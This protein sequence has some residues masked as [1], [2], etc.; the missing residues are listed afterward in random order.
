MNNQFNIYHVYGK[1]IDLPW[2][3]TNMCSKYFSET[4]L[5]K[6][7]DVNKNIKLIYDDRTSIPIEIQNYLEDSEQIYCL[8]FGFAEINLK[9]LNLKK[10]INPKTK[11]FATS[12]GLH[13]AK[14]IVLM[15]F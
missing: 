4:S 7:D 9:F 5:F 1:I 10:L 12:K 8:G 15:N 11:I 14:K 6:F 2:E 3:G 13:K